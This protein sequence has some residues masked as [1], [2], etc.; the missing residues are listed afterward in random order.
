M[1]TSLEEKRRIL[2]DLELLENAIINRIKL[3]TGIYKPRDSKLDHGILID[4]RLIP[5]ATTKLQ[6]HE[7]AK[8]I[9]KYKNDKEELI[10]QMNDEDGILGDLK[11][12]KNPQFSSGDFS[13][14]I[15]MCQ[16]EL[17]NSNSTTLEEST[18]RDHDIYEMFSS[19]KNYEDL[20][21]KIELLE[22]PVSKRAQNISNK[23]KSKRKLEKKLMKSEKSNVLSL[24]SNDL[25]LSQLFSQVEKVGTR[26]DLKSAYT[27]W[28]A[29]PRYKSFSIDA[30]PKYKTFLHQITKRD[31]EI[32]IET[33]EYHTYLKNLAAYLS[34]YKTRANPLD[35][36]EVEMNGELTFDKP[37]FFCLSCNKQFPKET[38]YGSHLNGKK[39]NNSVKRTTEILHLE[40]TIANLLIKEEHLKYQLEAT[41]HDT[42]RE[43]LLTVRERELEKLDDH[44]VNT[45]TLSDSVPLL[46]FYGSDWRIVNSGH[47]ESAGGDDSSD[48]DNDEKLLNPLNIPLGLDGRPIPFWLYK[49]KGLKYEFN[50]EI[51]SSNF[52]GRANFSKHFRS[53]N[54]LK[55]LKDLGVERDFDDFKDLSKIE[56][57][58][59]LLSK[60]KMKL[61]SEAQYLDD[62]VQ[63]EDDE[64][65][66]MS[67]KVYDQLSKQGLL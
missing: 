45:S 43:E 7:T 66:A 10:R 62:S 5:N 18:V 53:E 51:C 67:K 25:K 21:R 37:E 58:K 54:H 9:T 19:N 30:I 29:L 59:S 48:E 36:D 47:T 22:N 63:V 42:E 1:H 2:E 3:N 12:L 11:L 4:N 38:V 57:V 15:S 16:K 35:T 32:R 23:S 56:E 65:N 46:M 17:A 55:G 49:L 28:L 20:K 26:L 39:H 64:G 52:K 6:Q 13:S 24:Y 31:G 40:S 34:Q 50:C 33:T 14:F 27:A 8:L 41:I 61:R 44:K 60:L